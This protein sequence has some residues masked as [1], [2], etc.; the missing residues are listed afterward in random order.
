LRSWSRDGAAA[1]AY[2]LDAAGQAP[3]E[4][5]GVAISRN[6]DAIA[7]ADEGSAVWLAWPADKSVRRVAT[8]AAARSVAALP[9]GAGFA[10]GLADGTVVRIARDGTALDPPLKAIEVGAVVR[11]VVAPDGQSLIVVAVDDYS[12]RHL[13]WDGKELARPYRAGQ[14]EQIMGAFFQGAAPMLIMR[15]SLSAG[16]EYLSIVDFAPPAL[17]RA[18]P[19]EEPQP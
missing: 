5:S 18:S 15:N 13:A 8:A 10:V 19:F 14:T 7:V 3:K 17:R 2:A 11:I 6:G 4:L 16:S 12:A 1:L 9:D